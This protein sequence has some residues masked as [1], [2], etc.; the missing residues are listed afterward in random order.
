M[1][2]PSKTSRRSTSSVRTSTSARLD[3]SHLEA[4][5][6]RYNVRGTSVP[7]YLIVLFFYYIYYLSK[8]NLSKALIGGCLKFIHLAC[9]SYTLPTGGIDCHALFQIRSTVLSQEYTSSFKQFVLLLMTRLFFFFFSFFGLSSFS[10]SLFSSFRV[11]FFA[12]QG[13]TF[14][15]HLKKFWPTGLLSPTL[16]LPQLEPEQPAMHCSP[17]AKKMLL[18]LLQLQLQTNEV[19]R[20]VQRCRETTG[21]LTMVRF[22]LQH[23]TLHYLPPT[24]FS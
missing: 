11:I 22:M 21:K 7:Q 6:S 16:S 12:K 20:R 24:A 10:F 2:C 23:S 13:G 5:R 3:L 8:E 19:L 4:K 17:S 9:I 18:T 14:I 1:P 15:L